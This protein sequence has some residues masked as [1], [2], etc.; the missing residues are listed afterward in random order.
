MKVLMTHELFPPDYAG[1]GEWAALEIARHLKKSGVH[2]KVLTTGQPS[3][4]DFEAIRT[5]RL[6]IHRYRLNFAIRHI[7][8]YARE[9]DLIHT[10]NY[11]A[12]LP[13]LIAGRILKKPVVFEILGLFHESWKEMRG[14]LVGRV[15]MAWEQF[16]I[17]QNFS[18]LIFL[19]DYSRMRGVELGAPEVRSVTVKIGIG[20][21]E[22][23]PN[24]KKE[25]IVLFVG[26]FDVRKGIYDVLHVARALPYVKFQIMGW[27]PN[28][29]KI[30][31]MATPNVEIIPFE[32]GAKLRD[33]FA[34][35]RIFLFPSRAEGFPK[36]L[37]E[38]MASGCAVVCTLPFEFEGIFVP[39]GDIDGLV[40]GVRILWEDRKKT[41]IM[42]QRNAEL[43]QTYT[44]D[45]HVASLMRIYDEVLQE[46]KHGEV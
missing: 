16:L 13:S 11:H 28:E 10:F 8:R 42:G 14:P 1:G 26:K 44:W 18:R 32:R 37:L 21:K 3:I 46:Y 24:L 25:D 17:R 33:L 12:C 23:I 45:E 36:A 29:A 9:A 6:P 5:I 40:G 43:A 20:P 15:F 27:G 31:E 38:A 7:V 41:K 35:A 4:S 19:S 34:C 2:L 30:R 39:A 22:Y